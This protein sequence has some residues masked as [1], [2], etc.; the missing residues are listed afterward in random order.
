MW[1][2]CSRTDVVPLLLIDPL[3]NVSDIWRRC[4]MEADLYE[5]KLWRFL[6]PLSCITKFPGT[7]ASSRREIDVLRTEWLDIFLFWAPKPT[8]FAAVDINF[9]IS[10]LPSG[11]KL[12]PSLA[13]APGLVINCQRERWFWAVSFLRTAGLKQ[14]VIKNRASV[15]AGGKRFR[16][17]LTLMTAFETL[18]RFAS[19]FGCPH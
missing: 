2:I 8:F 16:T 5:L 15:C 14:V 4:A 9:P 18:A 1:K 3:L 7:P 12:V 19:P 13:L 17:E 10:F 11:A 6:W